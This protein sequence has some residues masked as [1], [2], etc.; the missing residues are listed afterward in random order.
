MCPN[1][2][3]AMVYTSAFKTGFLSFKTVQII[4]GKTIAPKRRLLG[5][6]GLVELGEGADLVKGF[7]EWVQRGFPHHVC[8]VAGHHAD[9]IS[10]YC[11]QQGVNVIQ[12]KY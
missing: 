9:R 2:T 11:R 6:N 7:D 12:Q 4:S 10:A 3:Y 8:V 5:N 1:T